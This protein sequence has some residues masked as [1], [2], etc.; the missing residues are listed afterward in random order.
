MFRRINDSGQLLLIWRRQSPTLFGLTWSYQ[1][2]S[3]R[4][5]ERGI[6]LSIEFMALRTRSSMSIAARRSGLLKIRNYLS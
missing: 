5:S 4:R 1:A 2:K 6:A 3:G